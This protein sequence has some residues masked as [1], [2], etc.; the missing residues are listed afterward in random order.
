MRR[1]GCAGLAVAL[2]GSQ[3]L[4]AG[5]DRDDDERADR[6]CSLE[7]LRGDYGIQIQG[8]R[9]SSGGLESVI[10]VVM[11][12]YDGQGAFRQV[13]DI[14]GSITG[15]TLDQVVTGTYHVDPDCTGFTQVTAGP[16]T[17]VDRFVIVGDG[18]EVLASVMSPPPSMV[19]AVQKRIPVR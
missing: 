14:H 19:N 1:M 16:I 9:P 17:I 6:P 7:T 11:R 2:G 5:N 18:R 8:T 12:T 4:G 3:R 15:A 13:G 10:G